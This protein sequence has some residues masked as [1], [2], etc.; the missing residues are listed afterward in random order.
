M[1]HVQLEGKKTLDHLS[2]THRDAYKTLPHPLFAK[3]DQ[4]SILMIP[5]YK[6]KLKQEVP[7]T[8]SISGQMTSMLRYRTVLLAE[9]GIC[10]GIHPMA[11]RTIPPQ[12][13]ALAICASTTSFPQ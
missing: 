4:N 10:Y 13:P 3:S 7:M 12:P 6:I 1:S 9:T 8:R 11:L 2:S 5:A